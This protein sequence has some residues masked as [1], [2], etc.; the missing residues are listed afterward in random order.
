MALCGDHSDS[1][2]ARAVRFD[3]RAR[4]RSIREFCPELWHLTWVVHDGQKYAEQMHY[5]PLPE[6]L[7]Q[8]IDEKLKTIKVP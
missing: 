8:R 1:K 5:V 7:M 2:A 6:K 3:E 4:I